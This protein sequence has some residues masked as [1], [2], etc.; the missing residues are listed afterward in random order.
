MYLEK[1]I[2][3]QETKK[4]FFLKADPNTNVSIV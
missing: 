1:A 2:S 4:D 3:G